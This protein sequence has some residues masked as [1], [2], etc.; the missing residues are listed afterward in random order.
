MN[1]ATAQTKTP[2]LFELSG[3]GLQI[4]YA[5]TSLEGSPQFNYHDSNRSKLFKGD[6][7]RT[8]ETEIGKF[9]SV[10]IDL[11]VDAGSTTFTLLV[12]RVNL[13]SSDSAQIETD[14]ITTLHKSGII[15]P[16][17]QTELYTIHALRGL[18]AFVIF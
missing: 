11:T 15:P 1:A 7:I 2:N 10:T 16:N 3:C 14:G 18:A 5:V 9:V 6:Q 4:T 12:P 17:G 8:I 13:R